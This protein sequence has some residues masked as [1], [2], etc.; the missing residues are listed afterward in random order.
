MSF[1]EEYNKGLVSVV[2]PIYNQERF[3]DKSISSILNQTYKNIELIAVNDGSTDK[4]LDIM[5]KYKQID[6]RIIIVDKK[7]GGLVDATSAGIRAASGDWI[8]FVDPDDYVDRDFIF[9]LLSQAGENTDIVAGGIDVIEYNCNKT[10]HKAVFLD[11]EKKYTGKQL[12][13]LKRDFFWDKKK[14][15]EI[16]P[17]FHSRCNK[18]YRIGIVKSIV[19]DYS[20]YKAVSMGEDSMFTYLVLRN[21]NEV[22]TCARPAG[23]YYCVRRDSSMTRNV[24]H[25]KL[26]EKY[27]TTLNNYKQLL[28]EKN[29]NKDMAYE[30]FYSQVRFSLSQI[31]D[32]YCAYKELCNRLRTDL[33]YKETI[34]LIKKNCDYI[35]RIKIIIKHNIETKLPTFF[36]FIIRKIV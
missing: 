2:V 34:S 32:D 10:I 9:N 16:R 33:E 4:S 19:E 5:N 21:A 24:D 27:L 30:L 6:D 1:S 3:L 7:N 23:Y 12:E 25:N 31:T 35:N 8:S 18:I 13:I 17:I 29:D 20:R 28:E 22:T 36:S 14:A 11:N 15:K 26:Y